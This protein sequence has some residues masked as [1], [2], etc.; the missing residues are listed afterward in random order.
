MEI[1]AN[2]D[3]NQTLLKAQSEEKVNI[4][5]DPKV[6]TSDAPS[7]EKTPEIQTETG[8]LPKKFS[9]KTIITLLILLLI[10]IAAV[11][12]IFLY[13]QSNK[14]PE[15]LTQVSQA[16]PTPFTF[17]AKVEYL[18]GSAYKIIEER[19]VEIL[20][21]DILNEGD[22]IETGT[23]TRLVLSLDD[24][25][26]IRV[27]AES[28]VTL[29][30]MTS[31]FSSITQ[32]TGNVFYRVNKDENH[33]F[34]VLAGEV[35]IESLGTAYSV[36]KEEKV[37][38]KVFESKVKVLSENTE[39]EVGT[40]QEWNELSKEVT[41]I[42][43]KELSESEFYNWSLTEE[44][45]ISPTPTPTPKPIATAKPAVSNS[46]KI[47]AYAKKV[48]GGI[49]ITWESSIDSPKGYKVIKNL[50]GNPIYPG[51]EF[52]YLNDANARSVKWELQDG[53]TW[54]FRVCQYL[55]GK[56]GEYSNDVS[57]TADSTSSDT[58]TSSVISINLSASKKNEST[59]SLSWT[60]EGTSAKGYKVVWSTSQNPTYPPRKGDWATPTTATSFDI[61]SLESGKTYYFRVCELLSGTCGT[62]SNQS[63][64]SF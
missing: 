15:T 4:E 50:T 30:K 47:K 11:V 51:D 34:E 2:K 33:K 62:Y 26:V 53:K 56:C 16:T 20:E 44:N 18:T 5:T 1:E 59:A 52:K 23:E 54:H 57:V 24:G 63:S 28:Q 31:P 9:P 6:I 42:D 46:Y 7:A 49:E 55:G 21:G 41:E 35:K 3:Q 17:K 38:V 27:D 14:K 25:S 64:L 58:T 32:S 43:N 8:S 40:D 37:K 10:I 29:S 36:E 61:G 12:G 60:V 48:S 45:L 22:V 39:M 13:L 19:K